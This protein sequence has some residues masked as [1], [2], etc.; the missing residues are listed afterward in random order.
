MPSFMFRRHL[1]VVGK[2]SSP[3]IGNDAHLVVKR[4]AQFLHAMD[5]LSFVANRSEGGSSGQRKGGRLLVYLN[6]CKWIDQFTL[7]RILGPVE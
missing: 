4:Y 6:S 1:V 2:D 5:W 7:V 3:F